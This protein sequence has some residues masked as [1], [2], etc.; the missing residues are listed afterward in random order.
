MVVVLMAVEEIV[1]CFS[2]CVC[3][4][5]D[6]RIPSNCGFTECVSRH[7][8]PCRSKTLTQTQ[9]AVVVVGPDGVEALHTVAVVP[10]RLV[11]A[12]RMAATRG[13]AQS[14]LVDIWGHTQLMGIRWDLQKSTDKIVRETNIEQ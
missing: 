3:E 9:A 5:L 10:A 14:A 2:V 12:H 7:G 1:V 6:G 13:H 11:D 4:P 8:H